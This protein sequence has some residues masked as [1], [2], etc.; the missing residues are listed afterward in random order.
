M[1]RTVAI[2]ELKRII[3]INEDK[4]NLLKQQE[5]ANNSW[6]SWVGSNNF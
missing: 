6:F 1:F 2:E 4:I 3:D 5:E